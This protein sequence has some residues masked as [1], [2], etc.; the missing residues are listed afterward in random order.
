MIFSILLGVPGPGE[1]NPEKANIKNAPVWKFALPNVEKRRENENSKVPGPGE[2]ES[3]SSPIRRSHPKFTF[4]RPQHERKV[5]EGSGFSPGPGQY[6]TPSYKTNVAFSM[7]KK[8]DLVKSNTI[9]NSFTTAD[10]RYSKKN[11]GCK[12][13]TSKRDYQISKHVEVPGPGSYISD[14]TPHNVKQNKK[15][16]G[17]AERQNINSK[18]SE[19]L[20]G[21]GNYDLPSFLDKKNNRFTMKAKTRDYE[22]ERKSRLP[23]PGTYTN[24]NMNY[25][26]KKS[27]S[28]A[29]SKEIKQSNS[30]SKL[31]NTTA[32]GPGTYEPKD[33]FTK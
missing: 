4:G 22:M 20:P 33:E 29:M 3:I 30:A 6:N 18:K 31:N 12:F 21:P 24:E 25:T 23:G 2:Y 8:Q 27:P 9:S 16:F 1:Y 19:A 15:A 7:G 11:V 26:H 17:L 10:D 14:V 5:V 32:P 28:A 13:G